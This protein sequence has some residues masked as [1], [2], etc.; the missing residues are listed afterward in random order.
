MEVLKKKKLA[1][2]ISFF[3][4]AIQAY[5]PPK[6]RC[7]IIADGQCLLGKNMFINNPYINSTFKVTVRTYR[8]E[9]TKKSKS[10]KIYKVIAGGRI[11]LGCTKESL[12][13]YP[14]FVDKQYEII[15]ETR[16]L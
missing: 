10:D 11:F 8:Q 1:L 14:H 13:S 16:I 2:L 15:N 7:S 12:S 6:F 5:T 9:G 4:L 3:I